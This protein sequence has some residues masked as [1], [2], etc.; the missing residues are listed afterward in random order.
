MPAKARNLH[1]PIR[2]IGTC[3]AD[4][5]GRPLL[6]ANGCSRFLKSLPNTETNYLLP[7]CSAC[8]PACTAWLL[9]AVLNK[10]GRLETTPLFCPLPTTFLLTS[11]SLPKSNSCPRIPSP[12]FGS[13]ID[14]AYILHTLHADVSS[15][16]CGSRW[17][18]DRSFL[19][20]LSSSP[21]QSPSACCSDCKH[22][23][24]PKD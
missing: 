16:N 6:S 19:S 14:S 7:L 24:S 5:A 3:L 4:N 9:P 21:W 1:T 23:A 12:D 11:N 15:E 22:G 8:L 20:A 18:L 17:D 10:R 2:A 13:S